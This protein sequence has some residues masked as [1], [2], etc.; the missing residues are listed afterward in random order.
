MK[1]LRLKTLDKILTIIDQAGIHSVNRVQE[2]A[3]EP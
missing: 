1:E 2:G 3:V